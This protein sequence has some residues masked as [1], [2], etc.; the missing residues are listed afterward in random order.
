[1]GIATFFVMPALLVLGAQLAAGRANT[2][3]PGQSLAIVNAGIESAEDAPFVA[4]DYMFN[5]GDFVYI[6]FEI[7]GYKAAGDEYKGPRHISLKYKAEPSD[8]NG[9]PLAAAAQ[10]DIDQEIG[11]EDKN[12]LPKRRASFL[13]P[14]YLAKGVYRV[15]LTV[16]DALAKSKQTKELPF[17]ISGPKITP[18]GG[19]QVQR[20]RF[21]RS[22]EDGTGLEVAAYRPGDTVWARFDMTGFKTGQAN[23]VDLSYGVTVFRPDGKSLF[24]QKSAAREKL[25]GEFYPPQFLPG[26]LSVTTTKDLSPGEYRLI[27]HVNDLLGKQT[28]EFAQSFR[29]E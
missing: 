27:V 21:Q 25:Q 10:G 18:G 3:E 28:T 14:S 15:N 13:L 19:L 20:F 2:A 6:V 22:Q 7:S 24:S 12:W 1:M 16:E 9:V 26:V 29:V 11:K 17:N 23:A 8:E 5:P 4:P